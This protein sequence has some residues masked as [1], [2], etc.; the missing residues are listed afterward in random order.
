MRRSLFVFLAFL[1]LSFS[2]RAQIVVNLDM[3]TKYHNVEVAFTV[4][5]SKTEEPIPWASAYV[6]PVGDT[7]ITSFALSDQK[8][9]TVLKEV[10]T[11]KYIL[12][13][14]LL[15][16]Y[17]YK[18]EHKFDGW[19]IDLGIIKMEENP[20]M[21]DAASISAVGNPIEVLQDTIIYNASS[22]KVGENDMLEELLKKM[23]GME[24]GDDGTVKVNGEAVDKITVGGKTFFFND[25]TAALKNLPAKIV[26]KIK[27]VDKTKDDAA[28]T[29][30]S[31]QDDKEKVMDIELKEE[32][33]KGWFGNAKLGAGASVTPDRKNELVEDG[34]FL[35]NGNGMVTGYTEK[36]Q[37]VAIGNGYNVAD[38]SGGVVMIS[39][40]PNSTQDE[41][42][43]LTG[44]TTNAQGGLNYN[45]D[46]IKGV[47]TTASAMYKHNTK[48]GR[49]ISSRISFQ[50]SGNDLYSDSKFA[51]YGMED[52]VNASLEFN[53][54][55]KDKYILEFRP[56]FNYSKNRVN[57]STQSQTYNAAG[58]LNSSSSNIQAQ[59]SKLSANGWLDF[60]VKDLGKK[61]RSFI[62]SLNYYI[63]DQNGKK[64]EETEVDYSGTKE[65]KSL[66]YDLNSEYY[67]LA[68]AVRY[69]EP[70]GE[71]WLF[72]GT[73]RS[74]YSVNN[75]LEMAYTPDGVL[76]DYYSSMT[77]NKYLN[78]DIQL[79]FQFNNDTTNVQFGIMGEMVQ[80]VIN[81]RSMGV[82]SATGVDEWL[83][84]WS[85]FLNYRYKKGTSNFQ[86]YYSGYSNTVSGDK[87]VPTLDIS[88]PVQIQAGNIYLRPTYNNN[89][90]LSYR[91][92]NKKTFTFFNISMYG[93]MTNRPIVTASWF[94]KEGVRYGVPV[95]S[96]TPSGNVTSWLS[97]NQ[98]F[99]KER[100]FSVSLDATAS[101]TRSVSY[102]AVGDMMGL[103]LETFDYY[104][105][106]ADFWGDENGDR[107]YSGAS[108]FEESNT[109]T[110]NWSGTLS[111]KYN[112]E[113]LNLSLSA[114]TSNRISK[115]S[116]DPKANLNTWDN[117]VSGDV[118][119]TPGLGWEL[120]NRL[121]YTF[122]KGY[123]EG[124]GNPVLRWNVS[125]G[126]TFKALTLSLAVNDILNQGTNLRR[127]TTDEYTEDVYSN[128]I[129]RYF[130]V[131]LS[132]NFGKMNA[133]K[134]SNVQSAMWN[135][136]F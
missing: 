122:Y 128:V 74:Q 76:D 54:K 89:L 126:K 10:P 124:Y 119:Y 22:F 20:E 39:Y 55:S 103:D 82:E 48:D 24:V 117:N 17:P 109:N 77:R 60:G 129:G 114:R 37:I 9:K 92:N 101:Y 127:T 78:E 72:R 121:G 95:N 36:D 112:V 30:V 118:T 132:F 32:Y 5:D 79:L 97:F 80:N 131:S 46:R 57:T 43:K 62:V 110:F 86:I 66:D 96:V 7:T 25:P 59:N 71:K 6:V 52:G 75:S 120:K 65:T 69:V 3:L 134:N 12:N 26:N 28:F 33:T 38:N 14:E 27:V 40:G 106:M 104:S 44:L 133:K 47:E 42:S 125:V 98:P 35:Y 135:M 56:V 50:P 93:S 63:D 31:T 116:L 68:G 123:S 58:S 19:E 111:F 16:Y 13:I 64:S 11:G 107:F 94:D 53:K 61:K 18:K 51:G 108:G 41:Y 105:F 100:Q 21:I 88:N 99:G 23:P 113:K 29:G 90:N 8:G 91:V 34:K 49:R 1:S 87:I 115:Y 67:L 15:G 45:T 136:M 102:Q 4:V 85:P 70:I 73:V 81:A 83:F 130:L 2:A 84:N